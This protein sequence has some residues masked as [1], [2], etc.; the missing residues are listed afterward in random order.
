M[1][2]VKVHICILSNQILQNLLPLGTE[3]IDLLLLAATKEM[4]NDDNVTHMERV[5][6]NMA[7]IGNDTNSMDDTFIPR[8]KSLKVLEVMPSSNLAEISAWAERQIALL[9]QEAPNAQITLNATGGTKI[10]SFGLIR[11]LEQPQLKDRVK[12]IYC[13]TKNATLETIYPEIEQT[14]LV[15]NMLSSENI[16]QAHDICIKEIVSNQDDWQ[17]KVRSRKNL[18]DYLGKNM[19]K[20][21]SELVRVLNREITKE[22]KNTKDS[23]NKELTI[24]FKNRPQGQWKHALNL[25]VQH[26]LIKLYPN[27][28]DKERHFATISTVDA[29]NYLR[30]AW[31]EEYLW[32]CFQSLEINDVHSSVKISNMHNDESFKDNELDLIAAHHNKLLIVEC[33]TANINQTQIND[34]LDKLSGISDRSGGLLT[35]KWLVTA[36]WTDNDI[37]AAKYRLQAKQSGTI[38]IEPQ[39]LRNLAHRLRQWK[40]NGEFPLDD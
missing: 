6:T 17:E 37:Q 16:L 15:P 33:K 35:E 9:L 34:V 5:L 11:A 7:W 18:T 30:G 40:K 2:K 32:L 8:I 38:L 19:H 21:L 3:K 1:Q 26:N 27:P 4:L 13:D 12:I 25:M 10:M 24:T 31:L 29:T 22:S 39:H 14:P 20:T 36:R 23:K 28:L